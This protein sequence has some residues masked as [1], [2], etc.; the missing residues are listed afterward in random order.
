MPGSVA[1]GT[2]CISYFDKYVQI[3]A[4]MMSGKQIYGHR[5]NIKGEG[6]GYLWGT[7]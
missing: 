1:S 5:S 3:Y 2:P 7:L 6:G 4:L